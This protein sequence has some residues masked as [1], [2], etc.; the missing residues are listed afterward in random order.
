VLKASRPLR[1]RASANRR[2]QQAPTTPEAEPKGYRHSQTDG[3]SSTERQATRRFEYGHHDHHL[4]LPIIMGF[5]PNPT[6]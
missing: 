4:D 5:T 2:K 1:N 6:T 3:W